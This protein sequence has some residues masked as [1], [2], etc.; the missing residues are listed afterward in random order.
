MQKV[1]IKQTLALTNQNKTPRT[2]NYHQIIASLIKIVNKYKRCLRRHIK[3][4]VKITTKKVRKVVIL[5]ILTVP[6]TNI[7]IAKLLNSN[8]FLTINGLVCSKLW[9]L[10]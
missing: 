9:I 3:N 2:S 7:K 5:L 1:P 10:W 4:N 6:Q 8:P